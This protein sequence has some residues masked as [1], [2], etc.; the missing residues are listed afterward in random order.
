MVSGELGGVLDRYEC[1]GVK[2][3][4]EENIEA[5]IAQSQ[6]IISHYNPA[7]K[8]RFE[9]LFPSSKSLKWLCSYKGVNW[10][11]KR[12]NLEH[13]CEHFG[14]VN[15]ELHRAMPDAEALLNLLAQK[16]GAVS[17]F[18]RLVGPT[19]MQSN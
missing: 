10:K 7:D 5:L 1:V 14:V 8:P 2:K 6:I 4:H 13:L 15:R 12:A 17:Y 11:I 18:A 19:L 16:D 3:P 9:A